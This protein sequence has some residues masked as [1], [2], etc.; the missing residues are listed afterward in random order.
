M[1]EGEQ[2]DNSVV[3]VTSIS[4]GGPA[5]QDGQLQVGDQILSVDGQQILGY[6]YEKARHLLQQASYQLL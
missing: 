3:V 4:D 2:R 1:A 5:Q 6:S